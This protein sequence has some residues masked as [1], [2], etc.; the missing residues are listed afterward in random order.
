MNTF[1]WSAV[2]RRGVLKSVTALL[3]G[4]RFPFAV[5]AR[6][7]PSSVLPESA[8]LTL[9]AVMGRLLPA[10]DTMGGAKEA[11][12]HFYVERQLRGRYAPHLATYQ[13]GLNAIAAAVGDANPNNVSDWS[14]SRLDATLT[15]MADGR[16]NSET[17]HL[18]DGG[19]E[20]FALVHQHMI[21]GTFADPMHG[22]NW[23]FIGWRLIGYPGVRLNYSKNEQ[24]IGTRYDLENRSAANYGAQS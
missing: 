19:R 20:F 18:A 22:G 2:S 21:E 5:P 17:V 8:M 15:A 23:D 6:A 1:A 13:H 16:F 10:D 14:A 24:A 11:G 3:A 7:T 9:A 4:F 12:A